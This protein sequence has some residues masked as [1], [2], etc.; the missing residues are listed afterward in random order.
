MT[1]AKTTRVQRALGGHAAIGLL[2]SALLYVIALSGSLVVIHDRW[3][4]WEQ[5]DVAEAAALTPAAAQRAMAAVVEK[6][7][8]KPRTTHLYIRMPNA[9]LPR[10]VVTTDHNAWYVDGDGRPVAREAHAWTEFLIGL[11]EYLHLPMTWGLILVGALGVALAALAV[12]GVLAHPRILRDAFRLRS[13]HDTQIARADWHNRIGVWTLPFVL[14]V[15]MTGAFIGLGSV[16]ASVLARVYT[17]GSIEKIY[18]PIFGGEPAPDAAT[19]PLPD[20]ATALTT[21]HARVPAADPTYVIVH[22]P[23]TRG[24]HIQILAEHPRRLIYGE[25]YAFDAGGR[26]MGPTGLSDGAIGQQVAASAYNLH[27]GNYGGL[28]VEI[29]YMLLGLGLCVVTATGTSLWLHKRRRRGLGGHR[30]TACWA[31]IVWGTPF[32]IIATLWL[33]AAVG[34]DAPLAGGF[35]S[36]LTLGL[37]VAAVRPDWATAARLRGVTMAAVIVTALAHLVLL[38]PTVPAVWMMDVICLVAAIVVLVAGGDL[39]SLPYRPRS[40][41]ANITARHKQAI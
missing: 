13:R 9:D 14:A 36:V 41:S 1:T 5:P 22:D 37:V 25:S 39:R 7:R 15:T 2:V 8:G 23:G 32:A 24:Q 11:H 16:G 21:L 31:V 3:Q 10:A 38:R 12:T 27:F 40:H 35:W 20:I 18:A 28:A 33:R 29:A 19:A 30:L 34:A 17:G 26:W 6:D 4:R